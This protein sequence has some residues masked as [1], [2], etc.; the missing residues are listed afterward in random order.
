MNLRLVDRIRSVGY[1]EPTV[2][3]STDTAEETESQSDC[4]SDSV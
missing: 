1:V 3:W 2:Q 4:T